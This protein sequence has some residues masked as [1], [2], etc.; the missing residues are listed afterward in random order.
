MPQTLFDMY[1]AIFADVPFEDREFAR[2]V[3]LWLCAVSELE[4]VDIEGGSSL[5]ILRGA[6]L[7]HLRGSSDLFDAH[8]YHNNSVKEIL[9]CLVT[10]FDHEEGEGTDIIS[11]P[12]VRLAHYTVEEY[13]YSEDRQTTKQATLTF[14]RELVLFDFARSLYGLVCS[15]SIRPSS[16]G[17]R[18]AL[19]IGGTELIEVLDHYTGT[20]DINQVVEDM[21]KFVNPLAPHFPLVVEA[22]MDAAR[23][24]VDQTWNF[25]FHP[26]QMGDES[27]SVNAAILLNISIRG[28]GYLAGMFLDKQRL[29]V[30]SVLDAE[31]TSPEDGIICRPRFRY[32]EDHVFTTLSGLLLHVAILLA[33]LGSE[34]PLRL[35]VGLAG[36][37][38]RRKMLSSYLWFHNLR[39]GGGTHRLCQSNANC[40]I[41][42]LLD[43]KTNP[44]TNSYQMTP[45]QI[46]V[47][48]FDVFATRA[49][50]HFG[51]SP[52]DLGVPTGEGFFMVEGLHYVWGRA[53]PLHIN[54]NAAFP[55]FDP[56]SEYEEDDRRTIEET[57]LE[58][59][60][61][62][63]AEDGFE[64]PEDMLWSGRSH[65]HEKESD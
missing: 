11:V 64:A 54:R 46:A 45:L 65:V 39:V 7:N 31:V 49:L 53:S 50:L 18:D 62:D 27:T 60:A 43:R 28:P 55:L 9:G 32:E 29:D 8:L 58:F 35:L 30:A 15:N 13:L 40:P 24:T 44:N 16:R 41:W 42:C 63:F 21:V 37:A 47:Y 4:C 36:E 22:C 38:H 56:Y 25:W 48:C 33:F 26:L 59:G 17:E 61:T 2:H 51:A 20:F 10:K 52:D 1:D 6:A 19:F 34:A 14:T 3:L 5:A 57:L 23:A 12:C